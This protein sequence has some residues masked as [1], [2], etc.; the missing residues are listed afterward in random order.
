MTLHAA[1]A[2]MDGPLQDPHNLCTEWPAA[3]AYHQAPWGDEGS[4]RN[5][6]FGC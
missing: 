2:A 5:S 6:D 1:Q 3:S 4:V